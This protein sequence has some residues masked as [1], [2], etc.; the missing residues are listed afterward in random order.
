[1]AAAKA[2]VKLTVACSVGVCSSLQTHSSLLIILIRAS[3]KV[4]FHIRAQA[5]LQ[6][7]AGQ[8]VTFCGWGVR[9]LL[10]QPL[11]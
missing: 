9:S 8:R 6:A 2:A 3:T 7:F 1:M 11:H 4:A 10:W 5:K